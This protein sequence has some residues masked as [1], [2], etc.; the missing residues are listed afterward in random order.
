MGRDPISW[1][2]RGQ[3][4]CTRL[5][6]RITHWLNF[7]S[8]RT[9]PRPSRLQTKSLECFVNHESSVV[10]YEKL[11]PVS[12]EATSTGGTTRVTVGSP[13][14]ELQTV[15]NGETSAADFRFPEGAVILDNNLFDHYLILMY[16][17]QTGQTNFPVFCSA[18]P[19]NPQCYCSKH[20]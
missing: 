6:N 11:I 1:I 13:T 20:R 14:S 4:A 16:R 10:L 18:V 7:T 2:R 12:Y 3:N 8:R 5:G 15:V 19:P 9:K 17:V